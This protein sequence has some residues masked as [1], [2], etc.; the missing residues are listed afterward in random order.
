MFV[1]AETSLEVRDPKYL[2][3]AEGRENRKINAPLGQVQPQMAIVAIVAE[4]LEHNF[5]ECKTEPPPRSDNLAPKQNDHLV[6][7]K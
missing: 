6:V 3:N 1:L 5:Q 4:L 7:K 2:E